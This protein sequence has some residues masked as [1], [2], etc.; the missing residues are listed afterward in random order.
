MN[1]QHADVL[2]DTGSSQSFTSLHLVR[3]HKWKMFPASGEVLMASTSQTSQVHGYCIATIQLP[4]HSYA[5][6]KLTVLPD[7]CA[8]VIMGHDVLNQHESVE[9]PFG[10]SRPSLTVCGL[11][12]MAVPLPT[13]FG[14][15]TPD[16]RPVA[17]KSRRYTTADTKFI[18]S[19]VQRMQAE[20]II[21]PSRSPWRAQ[22]LVT[23]N[24]N[25]KKRLV[26]DYSQTVNRFTQLDAY[27]LPNIEKL[28]GD[29]ARYKV[30]STLDLRS[31]YHQIPIREDEKQY[32]AF[33]ADG[34]LFQFTRIPFGVT[35]GVA[36]FQ[37]VMDSIVSEE[38]LRDT[39]V[40]LDNITV[41]GR[42]QE[43]HDENLQKLIHVAKK[44]NLT[45]NE[46]KCSYSVSSVNLLGYVIGGGTLRP[47]PERLR[48]LQELPP[49]HDS[50][51]LQRVLGMFAHYSH[52]IHGFSEKIRPL[53]Q[54]HKFPLQK[55]AL[56]AFKTL[57]Q[58]IAD[59]TIAAIRDD[60]PFVVETDASDHAIAA[61][62][63][64]DER[65]IAFFSRTL[66]TS[67][68]NHSA[69]EKEAY[70]IV[71]ALRRWKHFLLGRQFKLI[72]DQRSVA[73]MF[74]GKQMGKVKNEKI[75]RWRLELSAYSYDIVYRPG[76]QNVSADTLSRSGVCSS[77]NNKELLVEL[78]RS[79]CHPGVARMAH[80]VRTRNLPFSVEDVKQMT[81][82]CPICAECKPQ[83][84]K[85]R[86]AQL[87]KATQPFERLNLDFKGPLPTVS[88]NRYMLTI[89]DEYSRFPFVFP[90]TD[91]TSATVI[92]CLCQ[93][94]AIFGMPAYIHSDR[95]SSFVSAE[96]KSFLSSKGIS[97]SQSTA[98][99][100]RG[101]GQVERY[102]GIIWKAVSLALR[103][104][105][106]PVQNWEAVLPDALHS[107]RSL[108]STSTNETPHERLF[109]YQRRS[110]SGSSVPT[111]LSKSGEVVL[112]KRHVRQ[113][114]DPLVDEV[115]LLEANPHYAHVRL[116]DGR[117][118]T[119]SV[120]HLAPRGTLDTS[121]EAPNDRQ[122]GDPDV[123]RPAYTRPD[124]APNTDHGRA[125][126]QTPERDPAPRLT[127][128][129]ASSP[130]SPQPEP[131]PVPSEPVTLRRSGRTSR[132]PA[133]LTQDYVL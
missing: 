45:F 100:P 6:V 96:L 85:P 80:F 44:C 51:S 62:L 48:P 23:A 39:F 116:P 17:V 90:C 15:L 11:A 50:A 130:P 66:S 101:N 128:S 99:N 79:L 112:M 68:R 4:E 58:N 26:I 107:V 84:A 64:Q 88:R 115:E 5:D 1:G 47:D 28:V 119:V 103:S 32:T 52:W 24:E 121:A 8:D 36:A 126:S 78:H 14:N 74:D 38:G 86:Q 67:E 108:L 97:S 110:T 41:C 34:K 9:I 94:F 12:T 131:S 69:V 111:W 7:L 60:L 81:S 2:I 98:Y 43:E 3:K 106:L 125:A 114:Y 105:D 89:V 122:N 35:N 46:D 93:L 129:P 59:A 57:K 63:C 72:T 70:A 31:A 123:E 40:Y 55:P 120:R 71:E 29:V 27:P 18:E 37:R 127:D 118:T 109:R 22:V 49:P 92:N 91:I 54:S 132:M 16:C 102:N 77:I 83:Y 53:V 10:G 75:M 65:P 21:E 124:S 20:G 117:E 73:F 30:F 82:S 133:H 25:H 104:R 87:I 56:D 95:G 19:E 42:D 13:L 33:E 61:T 76:T 113:K